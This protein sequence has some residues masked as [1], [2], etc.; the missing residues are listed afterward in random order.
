VAAKPL[1]VSR[2]TSSTHWQYPPKRF[3]RDGSILRAQN[4][5]LK[6]RVRKFAALFPIWERKKAR[7]ELLIPRVPHFSRALCARS[8]DFDF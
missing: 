4:R 8:G 7:P 3:V 1:D 5:P 6:S 2:T